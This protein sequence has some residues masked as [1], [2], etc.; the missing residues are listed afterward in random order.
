MAGEVYELRLA[1]GAMAYSIAWYE[2]VC[3]FI[4]CVLGRDFKAIWELC[5]DVTVDLNVLI[6]DKIPS[7]LAFDFCH[8]SIESKEIGN[9]IFSVDE[10][11]CVIKVGNIGLDVPLFLALL[12]RYI[13]ESMDRILRRH[14]W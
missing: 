7:F 9:N 4:V 12:N 6:A 1:H 5:V 2:Y 13:V 14:L 3:L 8:A 10:S 11:A